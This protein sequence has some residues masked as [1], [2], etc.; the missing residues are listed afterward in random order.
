MGGKNMLE[1]SEMTEDA[2]ESILFWKN[3]L[4]MLPTD[5]ASKLYT[6]FFYK[7]H[8]YKQHQFKYGKKIKHKLSNTL[9][10]NFCY[11]KIIPY[12]RPRYHPKMIGYILKNI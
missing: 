4:F 12:L 10:L 9:R 2:Y 6:R 1:L 7:Q 11:L 5:A 3:N 8:F